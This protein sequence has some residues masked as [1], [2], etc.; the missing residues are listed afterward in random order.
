MSSEASTQAITAQLARH[1]PRCRA[2]AYGLY[3]IGLDELPRVQMLRRA[4]E[5][6][7]A[8]VIADR[9]FTEQCAADRSLL[10]EPNQEQNHDNND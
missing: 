3:L 2:L 10:E 1:G 6:L 8:A 9:P 5:Y 7:S 4:T